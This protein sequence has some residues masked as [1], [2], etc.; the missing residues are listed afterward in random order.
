MTHKSVSP[1]ASTTD[2][3]LLDSALSSGREDRPSWPALVNDLRHR[4]TTTK[5]YMSHQH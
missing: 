2:R 5:P 3:G 1:R 4:H